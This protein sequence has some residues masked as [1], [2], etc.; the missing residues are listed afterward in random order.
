MPDEAYDT[1]AGVYEFLVPEPL[2]SPQGSADAFAPYLD[3]VEPGGRVLDCAAGT[4]ALAVGLALRGFEVV[5]SDASA[6]MVERT[7][8]LAARHRADLTAATCPWDDLGRHGWEPFDAVLC[9]GNSLT[10]A[11]GADGRRRALRAMAGVLR[12]GGLLLVTSRN[13]ERVRAGGS[14]VR[15]ADELTVR[16]GVRGLVVHGWSL[17][18]TW[19]EPHHLD[20]AVALLGDGDRVTTHRERLVFWPFRHQTLDEEL[21]AVGLEPVMSTYE[22]GADRYLVSARRRG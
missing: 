1:L 21:R 4:G 3:D 13:W 2:L 22:A 5:A 12:P 10:H 15:V 19:D 9:V 18:P 7:R 17:A 6:A 11:A 20:V 14:G 16:D 8:A